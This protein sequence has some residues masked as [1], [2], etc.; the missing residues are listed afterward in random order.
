M[1][2]GNPTMMVMLGEVGCC[3]EREGIVLLPS[4]WTS[5]MQQSNK[6]EVI[7]LGCSIASRLFLTKKRQ[8]LAI[9]IWVC[10]QGQGECTQLLKIALLGEVCE[11]KNSS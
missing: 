9:F 1:I 11:N 8:A 3:V 10:S 4:L 5:S 6:I 2:V 7:L